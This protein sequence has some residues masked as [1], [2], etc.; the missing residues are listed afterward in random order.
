MKKS[1]AY[2]AAMCAVLKDTSL[3]SADSLEI[4]RVLLEDEKLAL[5]IEERDEKENAE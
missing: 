1:D 3:T 5:Y 2:K 4:I